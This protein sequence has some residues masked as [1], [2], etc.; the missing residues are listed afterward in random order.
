MN[1]GYVIIIIILTH[2]NTQNAD[3][4]IIFASMW[5]GISQRSGVVS[6][7][8][9]LYI[10]SLTRDILYESKGNNQII[11]YAYIQIVSFGHEN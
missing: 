5:A 9:C 1:R 11:P 6:R 7:S 10:K 3:M 2:A 8:W 4:Q